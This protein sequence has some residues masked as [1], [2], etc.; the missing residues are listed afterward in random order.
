MEVAL[1][2]VVNVADNGAETG[3][4][5]IY[6]ILN[7]QYVLQYTVPELIHADSTPTKY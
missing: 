4:K 3:C 7:I 6:A 2:L 1:K 5:N